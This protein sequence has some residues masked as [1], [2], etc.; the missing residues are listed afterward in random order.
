MNKKIVVVIIGILVVGLGIYY[1]MSNDE[2]SEVSLVNSNDSVI[3]NKTDTKNSNTMVNNTPIVHDDADDMAIAYSQDGMVRAEFIGPEEVEFTK[4]QARMWD[5]EVVN[6]NEDSSGF[7]Y[8]CDWKYTL[9]GIVYQ[10]LK[11]HSCKFTTTFI[12]DPGTLIVDAKVNILQG[13]SVF[14]DDGEYVDYVKDVVEALE[15]QREFVVTSPVDTY[16]H[17]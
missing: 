5:V 14:D 9:E 4:G 17:P 8:T 1:F 13:R 7:S 11:D 15:M 3:T 10:E 12:E 6:S 16:V 2:K